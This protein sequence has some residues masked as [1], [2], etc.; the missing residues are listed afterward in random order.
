M[1]DDLDLGAKGED[2]FDEVPP[3]SDATLAEGE[4]QSGGVEDVSGSS[5]GERLGGD[6]AGLNQEGGDPPSEEVLSDPE[7][8][9]EEAGEEAPQAGEEAGEEPSQPGEEAGEEAGE[10]PPQSAEGEPAHHEDHGEE[11]PPAASEPESERA[12]A[13]PKARKRKK[14]SKTLE[15]V[16]VVLRQQGDG[17]WAEPEQLSG[18][19]RLVAKNTEDALR[20]AYEALM[21]KGEEGVVL[22]TIPGHYWKPVPVAAKAS[23]SMS[24]QIGE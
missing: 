22:V 9:G 11:P 3:D 15:R 17:V 18:K 8:A 5:D 1:N 12:P 19:D 24:I 20:Q 2:P 13:K 14:G 7:A 16:Y 6:G 23:R 10:E 21:P 4:E